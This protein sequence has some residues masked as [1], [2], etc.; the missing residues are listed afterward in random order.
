MKFIVDL[1][2]YL[3][4]GFCGLVIVGFTYGLLSIS[5]SDPTGGAYSILW[6]M[7]F[8]V[9]ALLLILSLGGIAILISIH[10]R[11]NELVGEMTRIA[12]ALEHTAFSGL[13][14]S[15]E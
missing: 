2:R 5:Q 8:L 12:D 10:D 3:I 6:I 9:T 4:F 13:D 11:H 7:G 14:N 1:F 15:D